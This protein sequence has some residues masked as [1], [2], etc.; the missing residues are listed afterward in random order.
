VQWLK[1]V[2]IRILI[3]CYT[4][5]ASSS[6]DITVFGRKFRKIA[7]TAVEAWHFQRHDIDA[8]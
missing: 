2:S 1:P 7:Y 4:T 6:P 8:T 3:L 5:G